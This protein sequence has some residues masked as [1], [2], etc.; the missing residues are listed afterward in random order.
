LSQVQYHL[1]SLTLVVPLLI[2]YSIGFYAFYRVKNYASAVAASNEAPGF[3][4]LS[5]GLGVLAFSLPISSSINSLLSYM[6]VNN[7]RLLPTV[8]ILR[9]YI[10]LV[11]AVA[12]FLLIARGAEL[13][14]R[15]LKAKLPRPPMAYALLGIIVLTS[16]FTWAITTHEHAVSGEATYYLPN[17]VV[18]LT[19]AIP[20]LY[21]WCRGVA[22][23][24]QLFMYRN[25][26]KGRVYKR[27]IDYLAKGFGGIV[28][29][30]VLIQL[31]STLSV[32]LSK[33][34]LT[35]MLLLI[36]ALLAIYVI[37]FGVVA[38]GARRLKQIEEV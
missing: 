32:R 37:A 38:R 24:Y 36:Y 6:A 19:L 16:M 9:N 25:Y 4:Q 10:S 11:F 14:I 27:A 3:S 17:W 1:L 28:F 23:T 33:L 2:I 15:T 7:T 18:I 22:A 13:L 26:V 31:I 20:Y 12:S 21:V 8:T 35:P 34:N 30:S 5:D 29:L